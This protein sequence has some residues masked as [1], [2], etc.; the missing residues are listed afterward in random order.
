MS[1]WVSAEPPFVDDRLQ[2]VDAM[3][4]I[5]PTAIVSTK[6][7]RTGGSRHGNHPLKTLPTSRIESTVLRRGSN[8]KRLPI[9]SGG[10]NGIQVLA[11]TPVRR[12]S[13]LAI[14]QTSFNSVVPR[15]DAISKFPPHGLL[16]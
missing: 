16:E 15:T 5:N 3:I 7:F 2:P 10:G 14:A 4:A 1:R 6:R 8:L 11:T 9:L 13:Q 12:D